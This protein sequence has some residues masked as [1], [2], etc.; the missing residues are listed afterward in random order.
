MKCNQV[1]SDIVKLLKHKIIKKRE[2]KEKIQ[3]IQKSQKLFSN[4]FE[5]FKLN[6]FRKSTFEFLATVTKNFFFSFT[7][8]KVDF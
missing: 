5:K 7:D 2:K 1:D 8:A 4:V 3:K 6:F